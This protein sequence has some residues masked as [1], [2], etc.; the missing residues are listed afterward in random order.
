MKATEETAVHCDKQDGQVGPRSRLHDEKYQCS[1]WKCPQNTRTF[2]E[3][4][5]QP[6]YFMGLLSA[7]TLNPTLLPPEWENGGFKSEDQE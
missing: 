5:V 3:A 6:V 1:K 7:P 2:D 4:E